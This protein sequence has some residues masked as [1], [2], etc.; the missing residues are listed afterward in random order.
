MFNFNSLPDLI[1]YDFDGV[2]TDNTAMVCE[3]GIESVKINRS[4]GLAISHLKKL[5]LKQIIIST[6]M[7]KVVLTRAKKLKI[8]CYHDI[9]N[10]QEVLEIFCDKNS[11]NVSNVLFIGN[12]INDKEAME[13]S[14]YTMCPS[15][16]HKSILNLADH[17]FQRKGG[18][19]VIRE[20]L[21]LILES[22][23]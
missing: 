5:G 3:N 11:I 12:D 15:D 13:L 14:G 8:E 23:F 9:G 6:E 17:V 2:M 21:D 16:A 1:V 4:D 18:E 7:N 22:K 10:K 20:L 19:G